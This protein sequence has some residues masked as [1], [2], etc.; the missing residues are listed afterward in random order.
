MGLEPESASARARPRAVHGG[1][2]AMG[3]MSGC[4][5]IIAVQQLTKISFP[6]DMFFKRHFAIG[7]VK[8]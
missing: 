1:G 3:C 5:Y 7:M 6:K 8:C 4:N 2:T